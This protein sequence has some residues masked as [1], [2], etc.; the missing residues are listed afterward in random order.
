MGAHPASC[1][2]GTVGSVCFQQLMH[3]SDLTPQSSAKIKI[4]WSF[5][6][7]PPVCPHGMHKDNFTYC[8]F[9]AEI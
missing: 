9:A 8:V 6:S 3:D 4:E 1:S 5:T 7:A 2:M